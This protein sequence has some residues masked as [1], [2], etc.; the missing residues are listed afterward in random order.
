MKTTDCRERGVH[1]Y[2]Y[3]PVG[4]RKGSGML[5]GEVAIHHL[6]SPDWEFVLHSTGEELDHFYRYTHYPFSNACTVQTFISTTLHLQ[7]IVLSI[8]IH[9][10][11]P[12]FE[13]ED[14]LPIT[15]T[16]QSRLQRSRL[17]RPQGHTPSFIQI[18]DSPLAF[19]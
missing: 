16:R 5:E 8:S 11:V 14:P 3:S 12:V 13:G 15:N 9:Q 6:L 1:W 18:I 17:Q 4:V 19:S 2:R 10:N 7:L